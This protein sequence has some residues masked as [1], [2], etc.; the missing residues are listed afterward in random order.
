MATE[1]SYREVPQSEHLIDYSVSYTKAY[2]KSLV[3]INTNWRYEH[4]IFESVQ[5]PYRFK[6]SGSQISHRQKKVNHYC[7]CFYMNLLIHLS[8]LFML[9]YSKSL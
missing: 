1:D 8:W 3:A 6:G 9:N 7:M 5:L 4:C 2:D